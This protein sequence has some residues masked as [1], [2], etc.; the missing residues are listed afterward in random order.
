MEPVRLPGIGMRTIKTALA[1]AFCAFIYYFT[2]R[3]PAF[4]CIGVIFGMGY[5]LE[6][7]RK[8]GGNRLFGTVIGGV[9]GILL[10][11]VYLFFVPDGH[12][13]LLMVPLVFIG[14]VILIMLCQ[15]FWVGGVQPGGVVLC[16]LLFNTP[17]A[18]YIDYAMNRIF[19]TAIGVLIALF[20]S[21]VFPRGWMQMWPERYQGMKQHALEA[22]SHVHIHHAPKKHRGVWRGKK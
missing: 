16:I 4:A 5:N 18:T 1:T 15:M 14:T 22:W 8:N 3:S 7:A 2:N 19:D 9:V 20:V 10:F 17:V 21:Y 6:D 11:R 12:H 13:T